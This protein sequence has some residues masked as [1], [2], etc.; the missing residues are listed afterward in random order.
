M[1]SF[2]KINLCLEFIQG[3]TLDKVSRLKYDEELLLFWVF[4]I[5]LGLHYLHEKNIV[6][7]DIKPDNIICDEKGILK[8]LDFGLSKI[9]VDDYS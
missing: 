9:I 7:R 3:Q 8:I 4:Q 1:N 6:H 2:Y 5:S